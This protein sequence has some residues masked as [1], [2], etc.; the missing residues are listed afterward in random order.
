MRS[1]VLFCILFLMSVFSINSCVKEKAIVPPA[2]VCNDTLTFV[3]DI[4]PIFQTNCAIGGCH[5]SGSLYAPFDATDYDTLDFFI[6]SGALL[7]AIKHTGAIKM[8][9][10]NPSDPTIPASTKLPD[11]TI[12]KIECWINNGFPKL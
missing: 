3:N 4:L 8:P 9:R 11:S 6:N 10:D 1:A 12:N 5:V 2:F 7:N